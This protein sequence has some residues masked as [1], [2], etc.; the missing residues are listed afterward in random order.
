MSATRAKQNQFYYSAKHATHTAPHR[1]YVTIDGVERI[2][3]EW[4]TDG[5]EPLT[6]QNFGDD[7]DLVAEADEGDFTVRVENPPIPEWSQPR[8]RY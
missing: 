3:T 1:C 7:L 4:S 2:Y 8:W 6:K 5:K